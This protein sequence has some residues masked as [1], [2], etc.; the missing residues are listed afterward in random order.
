MST[1]LEICNLALAIL[2]QD[3][4]SSLAEE[5]QRA[6]LCNQYYD[7]VRTQLLR[8]HDWSFARGRDK[9]TLIRE[10]ESGT[11]PV[12]VYDKPANCL[13]VTRIYN[14]VLHTY[15][16]DTEFK[17]EY[18]ATLAKEV[19]R[20]KLEE[21]YVEYVRNIS[22]T[23][24]FDPLFVEA[25]ASLLAYKI[26]HSLTGSVQIT[27]L[28]FQQYQMALDNARYSNKVQQLEDAV[29]ANPYLE[30]RE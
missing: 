25:L 17:L 7:I 2:G 12:F 14:D 19:I 23:T 18:D 26:S 16:Q 22:D 28:A 15:L 1:K 10:D 27:Q 24:L 4:L 9:L 21:A 29:M 8:A 3:Y 20:T 30:T 11:L 5:N 13:F 6:V